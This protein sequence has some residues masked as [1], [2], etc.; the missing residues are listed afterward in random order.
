LQIHL[1]HECIE[2]HPKG[3]GGWIMVMGFMVLLIAHY[4]IRKILVEWVLDFYARDVRIK[5]L[6][7]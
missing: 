2:I 7:I 1:V 5:S 6:S 3:Y 4:L